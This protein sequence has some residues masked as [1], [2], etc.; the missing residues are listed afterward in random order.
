MARVECAPATRGRLWQLAEIAALCAATI[1]LEGMGAALATPPR[2]F[3]TE[4][5][6][7]YFETIRL[8]GGTDAHDHAQIRIVAE[9]PADVYV[10]TSTVEPGGHSGW[11][12]HPGPS[13]VLVKAGVATVY[14]G[15]DPHCTPAT[16]RA[17]SGFID[18]G[19]AHVHLVR[20]GGDAQ[21][22]LVAFQL[23]PAG[24]PAGLTPPTRE[25][26]PTSE[27]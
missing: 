8:A 4:S 16:Y 9:K 24:A 2:S 19:G 10:V 3:A 21:L 23:V 20:N 25:S 12:T 15:G 6:R 27:R 5:I 11:H 18:A 14:D 1:L 26:V 17:G 22:V 13:L 7:S